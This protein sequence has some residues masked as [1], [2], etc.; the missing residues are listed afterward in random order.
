MFPRLV[1]EGKPEVY[2]SLAIQEF[3]FPDLFFGGAAVSTF[4]SGLVVDYAFGF[5]I[6]VAPVLAALTG[7]VLRIVESHLSETGHPILRALA[8]FCY[9]FAFNLIR[10]GS[11]FLQGVV[12]F[13]VVCVLVAGWRSTAE[14]VRA[15]W[16]DLVGAGPSPVITVLK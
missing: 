13:I 11:A 10:G 1:W 9:I 12:L 2:G 7:R 8:F 14:A 3:L 15:V 6:F 5:G 4:P 16:V